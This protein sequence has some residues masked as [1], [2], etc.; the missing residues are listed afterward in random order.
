M[1]PPPFFTGDIHMPSI[2]VTPP[3]AEPVSLA[4]AKAHLRLAHADEDAL[5]G[6]LIASARRVAEA[7]TG[8]C[9]INQVWIQFRD[10]WPADGV[11]ALGLAPL[12]AVEELAVFG[13]DDQKAVIEPAHYVTDFA[14][15]PARLMLRGSRQWPRPGRRLNGIGIRLAAGYGAAPESVPQPLRQAVLMLVAHWYHHRGDETPPPLPARLDALLGIFR[16]VRL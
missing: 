1:F 6:S 9:L 3:A 12:R 2:L 15:R 16:E 10:A 14:S 7:R 5:I 4:E 8:L 11:I 13:E